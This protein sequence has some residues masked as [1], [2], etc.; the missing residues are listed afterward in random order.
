MIGGFVGIALPLDPPRLGLG[1]AVAV[2]TAWTVFVLASA[3]PADAHGIR[4]AD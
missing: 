3:T 4:P 2:L 1:V